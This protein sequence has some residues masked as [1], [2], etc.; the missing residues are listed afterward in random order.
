VQIEN[1]SFEG[2]DT[3]GITFTPGAGSATTAQ[4]FVETSTMAGNAGGVLVKPTEGIAAAVTLVAVHIDQNSG[5]GLIADGTGGSGPITVAISNSSTSSNASNGI[6]AT[7]GQAAVKVDA[8][9]ATIVANGLAG[10]QSQGGA[11]SVTVGSSQIHNN[12]TALQSIGGGALLSD[13]NNQVTG[14]GSNGS[15][16]TTGLQ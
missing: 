7:S 16:T 14:N 1:C 13:G 10:I 15:F 4:M 3:A 6:A 8:V 5:S 9:G 12:A 11:A 2:F